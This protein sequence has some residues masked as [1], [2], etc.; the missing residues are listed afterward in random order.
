VVNYRN[1][2]HEKIHLAA[3]VPFDSTR[4]DPYRIR[5][6]KAPVVRNPGFY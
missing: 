6:K 1:P 3:R 4:T 2:R 5:L